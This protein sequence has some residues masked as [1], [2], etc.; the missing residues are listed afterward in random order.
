[1][2]D[3]YLHPKYEWTGET[4]HIF[5]EKHGKINVVEGWEIKES[6]GEIIFSPFIFWN[7]DLKLIFKSIVFAFFLKGKAYVFLRNFF[8]WI[9]KTF[10]LYRS[11][12]Y[13]IN[14]VKK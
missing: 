12:Y 5:E 1:M 13:T 10:H 9:M 6:T 2:N 4:L 8:E 3:D 14:G 7:S 11:F